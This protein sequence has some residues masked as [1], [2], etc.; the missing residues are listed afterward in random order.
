MKYQAYVAKAER[1]ERIIVIG[2]MRLAKGVMAAMH[3]DGWHVV[4]SGP[5]VGDAKLDGSRFLYIA[6]RE[7]KQ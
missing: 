2:P 5:Y 7:L 4:R 3:A 1:L 6:E